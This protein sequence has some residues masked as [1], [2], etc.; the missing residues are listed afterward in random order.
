MAKVRRLLGE[1]AP[2]AAD[3]TFDEHA[4]GVVAELV[5]TG[6]LAAAPG[7]ALPSVAPALPASRLGARGKHP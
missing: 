1:A 4:I 3:G 2:N 6:V 5:R 7:V